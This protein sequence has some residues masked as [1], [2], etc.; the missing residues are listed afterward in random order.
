MCVDLLTVANETFLRRDGHQRVDLAHHAV[1]GVEV[2]KGGHGRRGDME[3]SIAV[4]NKLC[5]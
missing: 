2:T 4:G 1:V 5:L 3:T